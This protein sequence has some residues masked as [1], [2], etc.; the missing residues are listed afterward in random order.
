MKPWLLNILACPICKHHP[1][2][3]HIYQWD[4]VSLASPTDDDYS[5]LTKELRDGT[6]SPDAFT[7]VDDLSGDTEAKDSLAHVKKI[8]MQAIEK[9]S[10]N[11]P[12]DKEIRNL[13]DTLFAYFYK[14]IE[15]GLMHCE[16][17]DRWYPI[18]NQVRGIPEMLPDNLRDSVNDLKFLKRFKDKISSEILEKGTP[19]NLHS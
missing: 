14:E 11:N 2:T 12:A 7:K 10:S 19:F 5:L 6:I 4:K 15:A 16:S 9:S 17:C 1:L 3:T 18:G 13:I 8:L